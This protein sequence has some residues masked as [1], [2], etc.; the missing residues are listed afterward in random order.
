MLTSNDKEILLYRIL[1]G[2]SFFYF[3]NEKYLLKA[4]PLDIRYEASLIY[5]TIIN[6]EKF[7]DWF[8]EDN[9]ELIMM[10]LGIWNNE[11]NKNLKILE[12]KLDHLKVELFTN[13]MIPSKTKNIRKDIKN[14]KNS[15]NKIHATKQNFLSNTLEG[16]ANSIKNEYIICNTLYKNDKLVFDKEQNYKSFSLFN[17]LVQEIDKMMITTEN[18]KE[19]ARDNIWRN[20]W[21]SSKNDLFHCSTVELS[22]EQ[23]ALINISRMYDNVYEHPECP[24]EAIIN[25]DD[26]LEGWMIVQRRKNE[27][28]KKQNAF[29]S[30]NNKMKNAGEV[31][32]MA[33]SNEDVDSILDMNTSES[34][35][36]LNEKLN[37]VNTFGEVNDGELPDVQR[38]IQQNIREANKANRKR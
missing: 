26:A 31:F 14:T 37:Y 25:D 7:Q 35:A 36:R 32:V 15:I 16:Y 30:K 17:S 11:T 6:D 12:Q 33:E 13:F 20:Y 19:L 3:N 5:D 24:N 1:S 27:T 2:K 21:N 18:F 10:S 4:A 9:A 34:R 29:D 38:D 22:D 28:A 23:R 8:R